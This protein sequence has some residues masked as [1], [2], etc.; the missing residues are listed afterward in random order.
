MDNVIVQSLTGK[1][2]WT[3]NLII[4]NHK[5][6]FEE[7]EFYMRLCIKY[8]YTSR[9]L[10]RQIAS[11]Y[12]ERYMLSDDNELPNNEKL[13]DEDDYPNTRILKSELSFV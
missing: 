5:S 10:H 2:S 1:I 11:H 4:L 7:K 12:Y 8:N 9:E 13:I 3:N 6:S